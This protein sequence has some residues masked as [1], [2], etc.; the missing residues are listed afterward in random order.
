VQAQS[1]E[2]SAIS[3]CAVVIILFLVDYSLSV[4]TDILVEDTP[5]TP[6]TS[7]NNI[8]LNTHPR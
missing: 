3:F 5:A 1:V 6:V 7:V 8:T 4:A 2:T